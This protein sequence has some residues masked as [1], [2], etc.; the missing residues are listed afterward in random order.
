MVSISSAAPCGTSIKSRSSPLFVLRYELLLKWLMTSSLVCLVR[1]RLKSSLD[2][3]SVRSATQK[4]P[5]SHLPLNSLVFL[6]DTCRTRYR[7]ADTHTELDF[8]EGAG[9]FSGCKPGHNAHFC[10]TSS[11][12]GCDRRESRRG[13]SELS[14]IVRGRSFSARV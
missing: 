8:S 7:P 4:P 12:C 11:W 5:I 1:A 10:A 6:S 9:G 3:L 2:D 14:A 13:M